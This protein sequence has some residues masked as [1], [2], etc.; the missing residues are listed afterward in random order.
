M[1]N[2][3]Q[4]DYIKSFTGENG[5]DD[6]REKQA[7]LFAAKMKEKHKDRPEEIRRQNNV[8]S[9]SEAERQALT[10]KVG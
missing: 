3:W 6:E 9:M 10:F 5:G 4:K 7:M 8:N 1:A 2:Q